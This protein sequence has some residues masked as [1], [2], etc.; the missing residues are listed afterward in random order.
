M[1]PNFNVPSKY[2]HPDEHWGLYTSRR[3]KRKH[4][5]RWEV[6]VGYVANWM[7]DEVDVADTSA[8]AIRGVL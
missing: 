2:C 6:A 5:M 1:D 7:P 4:E 8:H 3:A